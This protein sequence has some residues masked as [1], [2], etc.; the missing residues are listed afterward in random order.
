MLDAQQPFLEDFIFTLSWV[1]LTCWECVFS[2]ICRWMCMSQNF[3]LVFLSMQAMNWRNPE[4]R[5]HMSESK[6]ATSF[7]ARLFNAKV[8]L[9]AI[10]FI[11]AYLIWAAF[12]KVWNVLFISVRLTNNDLLS[13]DPLSPAL[14]IG[15]S[16]S[17]SSSTG[18]LHS[19][20][21]SCADMFCH[22]FKRTFVWSIGHCTLSNICWCLLV[23]HLVWFPPANRIKSWLHFKL[24]CTKL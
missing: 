23:I 3:L 21:L 12:I 19:P 8:F 16:S 17:V 24:C 5:H 1:F 13:L 15:S 20:T 10:V 14:P 2:V 6:P 4:Y 11:S 9:N 7:V 22:K 18:N